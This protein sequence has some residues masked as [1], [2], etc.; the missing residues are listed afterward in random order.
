[1]LVLFVMEAMELMG[2][3]YVNI[4]FKYMF[5]FLFFLYFIKGFWV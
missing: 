4:L 3:E 2:E 1:M 5:E